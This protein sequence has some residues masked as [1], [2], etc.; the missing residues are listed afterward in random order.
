MTK[1]AS[2]KQIICAYFSGFGVRAEGIKQ[3]SSDQPLSIAGVL[4]TPVII[5]VLDAA[6]AEGCFSSLHPIIR[7]ISAADRPVAKRK[8][9]KPWSRFARR[10]GGWRVHC[11]SGSFGKKSALFYLI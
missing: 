6:R 9:K 11:R 4:I 2:S 3:P 10:V 5:Y 8:R 7:I 1:Y